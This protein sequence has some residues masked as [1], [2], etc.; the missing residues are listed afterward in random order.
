MRSA[1]NPPIT[2][3]NS[4]PPPADS[5]GLP[6]YLGASMVGNSHLKR[7]HRKDAAITGTSAPEYADLDPS[8]SVPPAE[9][10]KREPCLYTV[11][12]HSHVFRDRDRAIVVLQ[13]TCG[14]ELFWS[15]NPQEVWQ[16]IAETRIGLE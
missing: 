12:G 16:F 8:P 9:S 11:S 14:A 2:A 6:A 3:G 1:P 5:P 10:L 15:R 4:P 13:Q 7:T